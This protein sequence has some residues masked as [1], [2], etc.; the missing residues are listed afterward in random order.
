M[1][2]NNITGATIISRPPSKAYD[3][4]FDAIFGAP[5][6]PESVGAEAKGL[7]KAALEHGISHTFEVNDKVSISADVG[8][9][10]VAVGFEVK[11]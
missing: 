6:V 11:F 8:S 2:K 10:H 4:G 9:D 3:E 7:A 5:K 1:S